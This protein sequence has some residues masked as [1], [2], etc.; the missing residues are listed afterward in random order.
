VKHVFYFSLCLLPFLFACSAKNP[1]SGVYK[2]RIPLADS[3]GHYALQTAELHSVRDIHAMAGSVSYVRTD[4]AITFEEASD[5]KV[6]VTQYDLGNSPSAKF[7][8]SGDVYTPSDLLSYSM[9]TSTYHFEN[10]KSF[11]D[12]F[13]ANK[14][15]SFPRALLFNLKIYD[16]ADGQKMTMVNNAAFSPQFDVFFMMP[17][18]LEQV[19][20][21]M[22]GGVLAHEYAHSIFSRSMPRNGLNLS[23][24]LKIS[25]KEKLGHA[26]ILGA[27]HFLSEWIDAKKEAAPETRDEP[28]TDAADD[29]TPGEMVLANLVVLHSIDEGIADYFGYEYANHD[30]AFLVASIPQVTER[31]LSKE[32]L[33]SE[34]PESQKSWL[35]KTIRSK[36]FETSRVE[37]LWGASAAHFFFVGAEEYGH[38][39]MKSDVFAFE[40]DLAKW[41]AMNMEKK[42]FSMQDLVG[43]FMKSQNKPSAEFAHKIWKTFPMQIDEKKIVGNGK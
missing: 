15:L 16:I 42:F 37:H 8:K 41:M 18:D 26:R 13:D 38:E 10:I 27:N 39:K 32:K 1:D 24:K 21:V 34:T 5:S 43:L 25:E 11:F 28:S 35:I 9:A 4:G 22:N 30:S 29:V 36:K 33:F 31:D 19:P 12:R 6:Q 20:L 3:S 2:V 7:V 40:Q 17:Y 14:D 23:E